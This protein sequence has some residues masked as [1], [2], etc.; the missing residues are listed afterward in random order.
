MKSNQVLEHIVHK[1]QSPRHTKTQKINKTQFSHTKVFIIEQGSAIVVASS[2]ADK[3]DSPPSDE[4]TDGGVYFS[5]GLQDWTC[6]TSSKVVNSQEPGT[7]RRKY[8]N[9]STSGTASSRN[10][11][12]GIKTLPQKSFPFYSFSCNSLRQFL[13]QLQ[14]SFLAVSTLR[15]RLPIANVSSLVL[16][17]E[18]LVI[19]HKG[20]L[21][22]GCRVPRSL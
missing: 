5:A 4:Q 6:M 17:G 3:V 9:S 14:V 19:F 22:L 11:S 21:F 20:G 2:A 8:L 12:C 13:L 16:S 7:T 1:R 18:A 15:L 10:N